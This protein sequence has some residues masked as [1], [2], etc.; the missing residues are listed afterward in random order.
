MSSE[1]NND[2]YNHNL[3]QIFTPYVNN[4]VGH[5]AIQSISD[6]QNVK[7]RNGE[8]LISQ[9]ANQVDKVSIISDDITLIKR[10]KQNNYNYTNGPNTT[11]N[12]DLP[13]TNEE[14]LND[15]LEITN[16]SISMKKNINQG[17]VDPNNI[18]NSFL[19]NSITPSSIAI[20]NKDGNTLVS[21]DTSGNATGSIEIRNANNEVVFKVSDSG[22]TINVPTNIGPNSFL[23]SDN[24]TYS[25]NRLTKYM[26]ANRNYVDQ[27][28][29]TDFQSEYWRTVSTR[30]FSLRENPKKDSNGNIIT[31]DPFSFDGKMV[32]ESYP[33]KVKEY[34]RKNQ[35]PERYEYEV[36]EDSKMNHDTGKLEKYGKPIFKKYSGSNYV[37]GTNLNWCFGFTR[38]RRKTQ[39]K[40]PNTEYVFNSLGQYEYQKRSDGS[41][42]IDKICL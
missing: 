19:A 28:M 29:R 22:I 3:N 36:I 38:A 14:S 15:R 26:V 39:K 6:K 24:L 21:L 31:E 23:K 27:R 11:D 12:S 30:L 8:E 41:K 20:K 40:G 13:V 18:S 5:P 34:V 37:V 2:S 33:V 7:L 17:I 16:E 25:T 10:T 35:T 42:I 1:Q 4:N 9:K 32:K